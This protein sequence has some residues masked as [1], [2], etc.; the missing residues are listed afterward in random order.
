MRF[1]TRDYI[2]VGGV[3]ASVAATCAAEQNLYWPMHDLLYANFN[4]IRASDVNAVYQAMGTNIPD[5]DTDAYNSCLN[6]TSVRDG[7]FASSDAAR[8]L[9]I[10]AT[11]SVVVVLGDNGGLL[12]TD[13]SLPAGNNLIIVE[14]GEVVESYASSQFESWD[15][16]F[17]LIAAATRRGLGLE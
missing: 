12:E 15:Q 1:E 5:L 7:V 14:N 9:G 17:D 6:R 8:S 13:G 10:G 3:N 2:T 11:P 4:L 16:F